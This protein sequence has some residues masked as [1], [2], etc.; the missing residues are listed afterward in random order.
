MIYILFIVITHT[1]STISHA[2]W[3]VQGHPGRDHSHPNR[4]VLIGNKASQSY[5]VVIYR[6]V[7]LLSLVQS[8]AWLTVGDEFCMSVW[9]YS[10]L[11]LLHNPNL[12][13]ALLQMD[14]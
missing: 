12:Y 6:E 1:H 14:E 9:V 4:N 3:M 5:S 10:R 7:G 8:C 2:L 11:G 13:K